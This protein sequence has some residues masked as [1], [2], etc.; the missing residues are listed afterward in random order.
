MRSC[1]WSNCKTPTCSVILSVAP[2]PPRNRS[3]RSSPASAVSNLELPAVTAADLAAAL[4]VAGA[5]VFVAWTGAR[6]G[7]HDGFVLGLLVMGSMV[8]ALQA[9]ACQRQRRLPARS[10][11]AAADGGLW[12][13]TVGQPACRA[14]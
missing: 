4:L 12:L 10:L 8:L 14:T 7:L 13:H 6:A 1:N 9:R 11:H 3:L 2:P 5:T